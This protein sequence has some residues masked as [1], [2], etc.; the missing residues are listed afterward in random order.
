MKKE[1]TEEYERRSTPQPVIK[2]CRA[3]CFCSYYCITFFVFAA[4]DVCPAV[5][6]AVNR[7]QCNMTKGTVLFVTFLHAFPQQSPAVRA[8]LAGPIA[9]CVFTCPLQAVLGSTLFYICNFIPAGL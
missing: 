7:F 2:E 8:C 5:Q 6:S 1:I 9:G 4:M 3:S